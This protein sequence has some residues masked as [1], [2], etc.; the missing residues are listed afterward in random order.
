LVLVFYVQGVEIE[1]KWRVLSTG[2]QVDPNDG[3][4]IIVFTIIHPTPVSNLVIRKGLDRVI[5][6]SKFVAGYPFRGGS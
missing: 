3:L 1:G 2:D 6:Q 4:A 5:N